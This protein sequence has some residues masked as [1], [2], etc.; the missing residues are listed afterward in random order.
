[1]KVSYETVDVDEKHESATLRLEKSIY[2]SSAVLRAAYWFNKDLHFHLSEEGQSLCLRVGL[3]SPAAT[4]EQPRVR[5]IDEWLPEILNALVDHQLRVE[6]QA[7][8]ANIREL[9]IAKAFAEAGVMED[10]PPG[11]FEDPVEQRPETA[12][13]ITISPNPVEK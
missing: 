2:S 7:E 8:T 4:L 9:I 1:M 13:L 3:R 6:I 10:L 5:K 12:G 11:T